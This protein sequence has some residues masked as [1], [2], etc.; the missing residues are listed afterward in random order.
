MCSG[1]YVA[2]VL[3]GVLNLLLTAAIPFRSG[4]CTQ[5]AAMD[6]KAHPLLD[7]HG[8]TATATAPPPPRPM[9]T[10]LRTSSTAVA[11][12]AVSHTSMTVLMSSLTTGVFHGTMPVLP[13][14]SRL[15]NWAEAT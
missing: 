1:S 9:R 12:A 5:S 7:G 14:T 10:L 2:V 15:M 11:V 8:L 3:I 13:R 4:Q 6:I